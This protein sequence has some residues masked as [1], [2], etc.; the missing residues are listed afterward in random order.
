MNQNQEPENNEL[1]TPELAEWQ[2]QQSGFVFEINTLGCFFAVWAFC[3][4]FYGLKVNDFNR[5][6][7]EPPAFGFLQ[8]VGDQF[9]SLGYNLV[10]FCIVSSALFTGLLCGL[11]AVLPVHLK[12]Y[13]CWRLPA[14]FQFPEKVNRAWS[15]VLSACF[16]FASTAVLF[17]AFTHLRADRAQRRPVVCYEGPAA[18]YINWV[19]VAGW[20]LSY[21]AVYLAAFADSYFASRWNWLGKVAG[22]VTGVNLAASLIIMVVVYED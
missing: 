10:F 9:T 4:A 13:L 8:A 2:G 3:F 5:L 21:L 12:K 15:A 11:R 7:F 16:S 17:F 19:F 14:G 6:K 20:T 22:G 1:N 18:D